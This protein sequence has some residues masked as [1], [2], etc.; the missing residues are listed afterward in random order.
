MG[1]FLQIHGFTVLDLCLQLQIAL[2]M[3]KCVEACEAQ[4][5]LEAKTS[6][7]MEVY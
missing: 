1:H 4:E 2:T 7:V 3:V 6:L 5:L